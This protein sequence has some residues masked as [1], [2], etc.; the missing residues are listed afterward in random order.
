MVAVPL[1]SIAMRYL[2][3]SSVARWLGKCGAETADQS[4]SRSEHLAIEIGWAVCAVARRVPWRAKCLTQ[5]VAATLLNRL[6]GI[7]STLYLGMAFSPEMQ[8]HAWVRCGRRVITGSAG[9]RRFT[10][11][12][13]FAGHFE[14]DCC[15]YAPTTPR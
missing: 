14:R 2:H 15:G 5:A 10:V 9:H 7:S 6:H 1:A 12:G 3:F 4:K 11:V 8:A 13:T